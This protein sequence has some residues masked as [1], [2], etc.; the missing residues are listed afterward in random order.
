MAKINIK[1]IV[2]PFIPSPIQLYFLLARDR[3]KVQKS[4]PARSKATIEGFFRS[5]W[6]T[7]KINADEFTIWHVIA[8][9]TIGVFNK[10]FA[11]GRLEKVKLT[12]REI[13]DISSIS[14][15]TCLK[16]TK[17]LVE[18]QLIEVERLNKK[19]FLY[20]I[21]LQLLFPENDAEEL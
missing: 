9:E 2:S 6:K 17:H 12:I 10:N 14:L 18:L 8:N 1:P 11:S 7:A 13:S 15:E 4:R 16:A 3:K 21:N 20:S 5:D 19:K